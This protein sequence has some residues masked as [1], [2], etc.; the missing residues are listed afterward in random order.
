MIPV[1]MDVGLASPYPLVNS[2]PVDSAPPFLDRTPAR[3]GIGDCVEPDIAERRLAFA[4]DDRRA[5]DQYPVDQILGQERGRGR[6]AAFHQQVVDVMKSLHILRRM[7][8]FPAI[9]RLAA[10]QQRTARRALLE[11]RQAYVE[12]R[13]V[14]EEGAAADQDHVAV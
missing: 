14:S 6:R 9:D 10:G 8:G 12:P 3:M 13:S 4:D 5:V 7:Q 1:N 11:A 2:E